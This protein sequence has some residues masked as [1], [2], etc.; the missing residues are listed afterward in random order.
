VHRLLVLAA[1]LLV[2]AVGGGL[3]YL[4]GLDLL[5]GSGEASE[6]G[7]RVVEVRIPEGIG[8]GDVAQILEREGV[9]DSTSLFLLRV[10]LKGAGESL[11][12]GLYELAQGDDLDNLIA[13]LQEGAEPPTLRVTLPEGLSIDQTG[14]R[15]ADEGAI[16]G[17]DYQGLATEPE[18]FTLPRP[19]GAELQVQDLEGLLYPDT[20]FLATDAGAQELIQAQLTAFESQTQGLDWTRAEA[21]GLTPY[22]IIIV[23]SLIEKEARVPEER[24]LVAAVIYNRLRADMA[25]GIDATTRFALKKWTEPLTVRDLEDDSPYNTR[26]RKGLPPGPIA[27]P[28]RAALEAALNPADVD[29][30]YYVLQDEE[31][32]HFFTASYDEFLEAKERA[33]GQ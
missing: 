5:D 7:G 9:I 19:G 29:Y 15:L 20:Y 18:S 4:F 8:A 30:L 6:P 26:R 1:F 11:R 22:E 33:P 23:A 2:L 3:L 10:R 25:L 24:P 32:H 31:G 12:P 16:S 13:Q 28:G 17:E 21:L 27:S 14:A